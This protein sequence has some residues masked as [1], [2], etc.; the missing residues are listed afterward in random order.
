MNAVFIETNGFTYLLASPCG[1]VDIL[2]P[3][4]VLSVVRV[5]NIAKSDR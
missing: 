4:F 5:K 3:V 2:A 1:E